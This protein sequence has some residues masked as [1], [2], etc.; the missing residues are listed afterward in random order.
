MTSAPRSVMQLSLDEPKLVRQER[1]LNKS[2]VQ[3]LLQSAVQKLQDAHVIAVSAPTRFEAA[4]DAM[5]FAALALFA[6]QGFRVSSQPGHH[7][8]AME[9]L[10]A[11][12]GLA[13]AVRDELEAFLDERNSK[14]TGF[15]TV[16]PADL[17]L[18]LSRATDILARTSHWFETRHPELLK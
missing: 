3:E 9:G 14:Y 7:R 10:V 13:I 12:L 1:S 8:I 2:S 18:V 11:T 5:L 4:Y 17:A 15:L 6:A 16:K